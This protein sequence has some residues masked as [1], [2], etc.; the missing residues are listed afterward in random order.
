MP[1]SQSRYVCAECGHVASRWLGRCPECQAWNSLTEEAI[2]HPRSSQVSGR[3]SPS[4]ASAPQ[5]V[6]AIGRE[7]ETRV[8]SG[9]GEMDRV[10]GGGIVS[11]SVVLVGGDPGIGKST[12]LTQVGHRVASSSDAGHASVLY[13]TGEESPRQLR[14][15][16]ERLRAVS[17]R[18]LVVGETAIDS[19]V[20][21]IVTVKPLMVVIDS[22]QTTFDPSLESAPG[23]VSQ[24]RNA[25]ATLANLARNEGLCVFLVGH[26]TKEGVLAGPRVL[27]HMVDT[28][29][30]FEG[31][32][33]QAYR[34]LR[35]VKNR[36]GPTDELGLFEMRDDGLQEVVNP[37]AAFLA[38]RSANASGSA[39]AATMEG[40]RP[41][42]VEVQAL[43]TRS[44]LSSPRRVINGLDY[45]RANMIMA[46]LEKRLGLRLGEHDVFLNVAGGVRVTEP[47]SDLAVAVAIASS[48]RDS[49]V[50]SETVII[51]EVGLGGEVRSVSH[52]DRRIREA[53]RL[54]F[55][56][57][58]VPRSSKV[59][60]T[61]SVVLHRIRNVF[62]AVEISL[63]KVEGEAS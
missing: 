26:V 46:V 42:L 14:L 17:D 13:I 7:A 40:T 62:E 1:R 63:R 27:E 4:P 8:S 55:R 19:I 59:G 33:H 57:A 11:G 3:K 45:N 25:A 36:F 2:P 28:V 15:R 37:S 53:K 9:I 43:V 47:A 51:G 12:L 44:F 50:D 48:Y 32:R 38:E 23:T 39:V 20:H 54:G 5:P 10:L 35:A 61:A 56:R 21:H 24:V 52:G 16:C 60:D 6:V 30:Y 34:V 29:L 22:V 49:P 58:L 31:D 41:L 18:F